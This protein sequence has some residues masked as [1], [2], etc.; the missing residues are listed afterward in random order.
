MEQFR[1]SSYS[2]SN[3]Q[4]CV[5]VANTLAAIRDSKNPAGPALRGDI[6]LLVAEIKSDRFTLA[7]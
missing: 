2:N 3:A 6:A 4:Q 5:E 1:K 7:H